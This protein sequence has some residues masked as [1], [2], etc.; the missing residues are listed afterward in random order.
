M[1][2]TARWTQARV[3]DTGHPAFRR[4]D[5]D[6]QLMRLYVSGAPP[7]S[8]RSPVGARERKP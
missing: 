3:L 5:T 6:E 7:A 2:D 4:G 1:P 8:R